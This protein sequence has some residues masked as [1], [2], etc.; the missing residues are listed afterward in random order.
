MRGSAPG[1]T[2]VRWYEVL[3]EL[4]PGGMGLVYKARQVRLGRVVA[5]KMVLAGRP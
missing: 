3:G 2:T 1:S 5:L 4:G